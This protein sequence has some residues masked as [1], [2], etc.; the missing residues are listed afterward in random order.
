MKS[1]GKKILISLI[2]FFLLIGIAFGI[3]V[4]DY[5]KPSASA[6]S[7]LKS[8]SQITVSNHDE[9]YLFKGNQVK[10]GIIFYPGGKVDERAYAPL[11]KKLAKANYAVML[12]KMPLHLAMFG[13]NT[14]SHIKKENP[15]I[16]HWYLGGHSLGGAMAARYLSKHQ[17]FEGL[18]LLA[19]YSTSKLDAHLKCISIYGS[20]DHVLNRTSYKKYHDNL[21]K[22]SQE[23]II[24]GG[25][26]GQFGNYG[27]QK[28]DHQ[29]T[30]TAQQQQ[31]QTVR[32]IISIL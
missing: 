13:L 30:I 20:K 23:I 31:N 18:F 7:S 10:G 22:N 1:F 4:S 3:Y 21:P 8:D 9:Y 26:H 11:M 16:K 29:S 27:F 6:L 28:G 15:Q 19:S 2:A 17:G 24:Q 12:A 5:Y 32:A 25:N 14:A